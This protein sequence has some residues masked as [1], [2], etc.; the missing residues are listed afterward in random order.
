MPPRVVTARYCRKGSLVEP[1]AKLT[2]AEAA[3]EEYVQTIHAT[4]ARQAPD[5]FPSHVAC[6][7]KADASTSDVAYQRVEKATC[8][9][10]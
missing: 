2:R 7:Q 3:V 1:A 6:G 4:T 10:E 8:Q 9:P 5:G